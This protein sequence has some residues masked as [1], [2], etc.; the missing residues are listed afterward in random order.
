MGKQHRRVGWGKVGN[1]SCTPKERERL[2]CPRFCVNQKGGQTNSTHAIPIPNM[3]QG[4]LVSN[5]PLPLSPSPLPSSIDPSMR[6][7]LIWDR[8]I[9]CRG[10]I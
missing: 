7:N 6:M 8:V 9:P 3:T 10:W 1:P 5:C 4:L 2:P